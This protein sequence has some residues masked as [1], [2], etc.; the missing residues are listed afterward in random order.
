M[1]IHVPV[2]AFMSKN[3]RHKTTILPRL[4]LSLTIAPY[5]PLIPWASDT[6]HRLWTINR[7]RSWPLACVRERERV[8]RDPGLLFGGENW[9]EP[10]HLLESMRMRPKTTDFFVAKTC[11]RPWAGLHSFSQGTTGPQ[12]FRPVTNY[13]N[14]SSLSFVPRRENGKMHRRFACCQLCEPHLAS[15][16]LSRQI[17]SSN[18]TTSDSIWR[19]SSR[20]ESKPKTVKRRENAHDFATSCGR[21]FGV[22]FGFGAG[23]DQKTPHPKSREARV[24]PRNEMTWT[25]KHRC[26]FF[27]EHAFSLRMCYI[28]IRSIGVSR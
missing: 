10:N 26:S 1:G 18:V 16:S 3:R 22:E 2:A 6:L 12:P 17:E 8:T 25:K 28:K 11:S 5:L 15:D 14:F 24:A 19:W 13:Y 20:T 27:Q 4:Y 9:Q 23:P 21:C 7:L